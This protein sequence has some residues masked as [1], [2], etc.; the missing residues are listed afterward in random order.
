MTR[1]AKFRQMCLH[2]VKL[3]KKNLRQNPTQ[4]PQLT[5]A[6]PRL[7]VGSPAH[8]CASALFFQPSTFYTLYIQVYKYYT[9]CYCKYMIILIFTI[10][11][12]GLPDGEIL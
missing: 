7:R 3:L 2:Q 6:Q 1:K 9:F 8:R 11:C 4:P 10:V 5:P 12:I